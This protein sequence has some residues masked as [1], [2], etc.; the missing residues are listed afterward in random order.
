MKI[1]QKENKTK[2]EDRKKQSSLSAILTIGVSLPWKT[3]YPN[4]CSTA[5][6]LHEKDGCH[7]RQACI[8]GR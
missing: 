6:R 8:I 2:K 1:N 7:E 4:G 5:I 3:E